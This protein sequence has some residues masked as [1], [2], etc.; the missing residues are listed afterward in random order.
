MTLYRPTLI[1]TLALGLTACDAQVST[2]HHGPEAKTSQALYESDDSNCGAEGYACLNGRT[3]SNSQCIPA[4]QPLSTT[5]APTPRTRAAAAAFDGK[6]VISGGCESEATTASTDVVAYDPTT[7]TWSPLPSLTTPRAGHVAFTTTSGTFVGSGTDDCTDFATGNQSFAKLGEESW[8]TV[9]L[10]GP[11]GQGQFVLNLGGS[12]VLVFG[13]IVNGDPSGSGYYGDVESTS[14]WH[15]FNC[16]NTLTGC[17]RDDSLILFTED[18]AVHMLGGSGGTTAPAGLS[19]DLTNH[20]WSNWT[21]AKAVP[22]FV[23][24]APYDSQAPLA[25]RSA[26]SGDREFFVST[27]G[28][29]YIYEKALRRWYFDQT[30]LPVEGFCGEGP[31]AFVNGELIAYSGYCNGFS[32]VGARYQPP[33]PGV[34]DPL[35]I[36]PGPNMIS[37]PADTFNVGELT[38]IRAV[39]FN[40]FSL[41]ETEITV[42]QYADCVTDGACSEPSTGDPCNW[43]IEGRGDHPVNCVD[44]GQAQTY[45]GWANKRLPTHEE[46]EYAGRYNDGRKY[47]WGTSTSGYA[48]KTN[49]NTGDSYQYTA[50]V[51]SFPD[52]DSALGFK[53]LSGNVWEWTQSPACFN[54]TGPCTDCPEGETCSNP[55][56]TCGVTDGVT[57]P[58]IKGGGYSHP[59]GASRLAYRTYGSADTGAGAPFLGFRCALTGEP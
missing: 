20:A 11:L 41:D 52:G 53:D 12:Q 57:D 7:D 45:C 25:A 46:W 26:D 47:S 23:S 32:S 8:S 13:G 3:C 19:F 58:V 9:T 2:T 39:T 48:T 29:V 16:L 55:C 30:N 17:E 36:F 4:W 59:L 51:G 31:L 33:A 10:S 50:P 28:N 42:D 43:G 14:D 6:Y 24:S 38:F 22:D 5:D 21:P 1:L 49:T 44:L 35:V 56:D 40:E 54:E 18:G 37:V 34:T 15:P 27:Y